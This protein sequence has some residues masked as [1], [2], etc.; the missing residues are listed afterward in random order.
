MQG[1]EAGHPMCRGAEGY[2][3]EHRKL[4]RAGS[5]AAHVL[6]TLSGKISQETMG[7]RCL[8][9]SRE[10]WECGFS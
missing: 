4:V 8:R 2:V 3:L 6:T 5:Q 7:F 9:H 1:F 10:S